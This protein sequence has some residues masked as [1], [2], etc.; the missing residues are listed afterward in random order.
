MV[1][2]CFADCLF[3][4]IFD[5]LIFLLRSGVVCSCPICGSS[6]VCVSGV[7]VGVWGS[8]GVGVVVGSVCGVSCWVYVPLRGSSDC[9]SLSVV[10][11]I[12]SVSIDQIYIY[13]LE[14][15]LIVL[16]INIFLCLS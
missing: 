15:F 10:R 16:C 5:F 7:M 9:V 1:L 12:R 13:V 11:P 14:D 8:C 3:V 6:G 2:E 4:C